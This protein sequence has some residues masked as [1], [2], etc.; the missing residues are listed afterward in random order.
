MNHTLSSKL[1]TEAQ[2]HLV[3]GV[4]SPV[5]AYKSVGGVP[6]FIVR[7]KGAHIWDADGNEYIDYVGTWGPAILGHAQPSV[8]NTLNEV[9][10]SGTSFGAPTALEIQMA[11]LVK[12]IIP[13]IELIRFVNSGTE[14]TMSAI[15]AARG[16]TGRNKIIK[17]DGCYHGHADY[18]LV[19]AGSG[20]ATLGH[21][22]SL[23]V[24]ESFAKETLIAKFNDINSVKTLLEQYSNEVACVILEPVVGNMGCIPPTESFLKDLRQ[25]TEK[26]KTLL[27]FDEVMT[28]F[29]VSF[30]GA[31]E[32]YQIKPDLTCLGKIIGGGLP[33]GAYGGRKEI[34]ECVAPMGKVYQ[35]GTLSGN[36]LAMAAGF[37]L[38]SEIKKQ[39]IYPILEEKGKYL[40]EGLRRIANQSKIDLQINRVGSMFSLFF[41]NQ[42]VTDAESAR[43]AD[44]EKFKKFFHVM[45]EEGI[46]LAPSAFEAG[47]I[48]MT[49]SRED[50]DKTLFAFEKYASSTNKIG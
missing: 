42:P 4:N 36:P 20:A 39:K 1:F 46:Y 28:G 37:A 18:L 47:F 38:L 5:R 22:D 29:R 40:E 21:P 43:K 6:P 2:K 30:G 12:E 19:K 23:G 48:S 15:R 9:M 44:G 26:H 25:L 24:P 10:K 31:Q 50:L 11:V 17:F 27:I 45:L 35:A 8:L 34:M 16:F 3:G 7:A 33:V 41:T 14:A 13:S 49:H 32:L